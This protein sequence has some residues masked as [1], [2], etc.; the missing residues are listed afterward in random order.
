MKKAENKVLRYV[1]KVNG[2]IVDWSFSEKRAQEIAWR[3][4]YECMNQD[5]PFFPKMEIV[6]EF[7]Q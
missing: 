7:M 2:K 5:E 3:F 1:V 4:E 6:E